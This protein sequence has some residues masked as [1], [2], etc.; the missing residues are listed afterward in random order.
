MN[1]SAAYVVGSLLIFGAVT[2]FIF[3]G[4]D[5]PSSD[6]RP[7]VTKTAVASAPSRSSVEAVPQKAAPMPPSPTGPAPTRGN[8][9][10]RDYSDAP[11][12]KA[13]VDR[14]GR[15]PAGADEKAYVAKALLACQRVAQLGSTE[16]AVE[17]LTSRFNRSVDATNNDVRTQ[18][19]TSRTARCRGFVAD[20]ITPEEISNLRQAA[21]R[22]G[23]P[24][25]LVQSLFEIERTA[26]KERAVETVKQILQ[27]QEPVA[28]ND[29]MGYLIHSPLI[30]VE[31]VNRPDLSA[32]LGPALALYSCDLGM[33]CGLGT[34]IL[35]AH[36]M[37]MNQ[38]SSDSIDAVFRRTLSNEA[39]ATAQQLR[40]RIS[41]AVTQGDWNAL[42]LR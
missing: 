25:A 12:L 36:C 38:C 22:E 34:E 15:Y 17:E 42:G 23:S 13:F 27:S 7:D 41:R 29:L 37:G 20:S 1:K 31:G 3:S 6:S 40:A 21:A 8:V 14:V 9:L 33:D 32:A 35:T 2:Y 19:I 5:A 10:Y 24:V 18:L 16:R 28:I 26:G 39:Y 4:R 11:D 30:S